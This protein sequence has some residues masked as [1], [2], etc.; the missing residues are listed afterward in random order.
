MLLA[1]KVP[2]ELQELQVQLDPQAQ[3]ETL[4][5]LDQLVVQAQLVLQVY[6]E[7]RAIQGVQLVQLVYKVI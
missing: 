3:Q 4:A 5:Q 7:Q 2:L 1:S 6:K